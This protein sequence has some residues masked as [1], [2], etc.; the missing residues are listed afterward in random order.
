MRLRNYSERSIAIYTGFISRIALHYKTSPDQLTRAQL[1]DFCYYLL[2]DE[3]LSPISVNQM[4]SAWKILQVD[5]LGNNWETIKIKRPRLKKKLPVVLSQ[6]GAYQL[7]HALCNLKHSTIL[8]LTY[9]TGMRRDEVI[10]LKPGQIDP[11][12]EVVRIKG[13]GNKMREVPLPEELIK[14]L[15]C[16]YKQYRPLIYL[17]EGGKRGENIQS[18]VF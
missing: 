1:K 16:Y 6:Q 17:F 14:Q 2:N 11:S 15:R 9:A 4:L 3:K 8:K 7:I 10:N 13:K 12:R 5:V 18:L